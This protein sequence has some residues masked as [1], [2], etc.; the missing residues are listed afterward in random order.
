MMQL[1]SCI[2]WIALVFKQ[3]YSTTNAWFKDRTVS[4]ALHCMGHGDGALQSSHLL[5]SGTYTL[6]AMAKQAITQHFFIFMGTL[7][8]P[9]FKTN[10]ST[11]ES[12][13]QWKLLFASGTKSLLHVHSCILTSLVQ[14]SWQ[15][16]LSSCW[17]PLCRAQLFR[18]PE[19]INFLTGQRHNWPHLACN[20]PALRRNLS[21]KLWSFL[22]T[23]FSL[24]SVA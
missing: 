5:L 8:S 1:L 16:L 13:S 12:K 4:L 18:L 6:Q 22:A 23:N 21:K 24:F 14:Y 20:R 11:Y 17:Q 15:I 10:V 19:N 7:Q 9:I 3:I 2:Y